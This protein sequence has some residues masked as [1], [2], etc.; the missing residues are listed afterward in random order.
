MMSAVP[1]QIRECEKNN[2]FANFGCE[3]YVNPL[4]RKFDSDDE[5]NEYRKSLSE[6]DQ[7]N[8]GLGSHLLA[9]ALSEKGYRNLVRLTS[10]GW[11][12]GVYRGK[13]RLNHEQLIKYKEDIL[14]TSC[15]YNSEVGRAFD[16]Q[17]PEVAEEILCRYMDMFGDNYIFEIMMLD[18][19]KQ[20]EYNKFIISMHEKYDRPLILSQDC[21]YCHKE[22][23]HNQRLMLMVQTGRT[24]QDI[25]AAK[26]TGDTKDFFELQDQNLWLKSED[27]LN[28]MW[29]SKY[30]KVID[31][32]VFKA[33]KRKTVEIARMASGVKLDR[34]MKLPLFPDADEELKEKVM[35]GFKWRRLPTRSIYLD[36]IK[37][38]YKL[39]CKKEFSSYFLIQKMMVDEAR[40]ICPK[41]IG[42]GDGS[43]AVGPGRGC[44]SFDVPIITKNNGYKFIKD[45]SKGEE[46]LTKSGEFKK[47]LNKQIYDCNESLLKLKSYYGDF[48]GVSLTFDHK[49]YAEKARRPK[50]WET[51][52]E[53][54]KKSRRSF[55]EPEGKLEWLRADELKIGDWL[56]V[57]KPDHKGKIFEFKLEKYCKG[58][59]R[60]GYKTY[61]KDN[62]VFVEHNNSGKSSVQNIVKLDEDFAVILGI[63]AGDGWLRKDNSNKIGFCFNSITDKKNKQ[64][65]KNFFKMK[66]CN[67]REDNRKDKKEV[68]VIV[69]KNYY[70]AQ[71]FRE[72]FS[73]YKYTSRTKHVPEC[74]LNSK[75]N[76][77][78]K[79]LLG[80]MKSDG[81]EDKHKAKITTSSLVMADQVR[82][83]ALCLGVP[84]SLILDARKGDIREEFKNTDISYYI[85]LPLNEDFGTRNAQKN[86]FYKKI[87]GGLLLKLRSIEEIE[88]NGK[89]YD[90]EVEDEHNYVTSSFL[91][92]NSAVG[93][94]VCYC[95]GI[96]DVDPIKEDLIFERFLSEARGGKSMKLRFSSK[97]IKAMLD[98]EY[99][100][101][102]GIEEK[103]NNLPSESLPASKAYEK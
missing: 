54:T 100:E 26:L 85:N 4:Q 63:F 9:I 48:R 10:W 82:Y 20:P 96:T 92:H 13:P 1:T 50:N 45:V 65:V 51:W 88:G 56:F 77:I 94:L 35:Q 97:P 57:P 36:R 49:I 84:S 3:L 14:F 33:A 17:G 25:E 44:L 72:I 28:L 62:E 39:I 93:S 29:E 47:V 81:H 40:R 23:S 83:L 79:F 55:L 69:I 34:S 15:C 64:F 95:L 12:H 102:R 76:I 73:E 38:E 27:E 19:D 24:L 31:Y 91:V 11:L 46:V 41:I 8:F 68:D 21:H 99:I 30:S 87:E 58:T 5:R 101:S 103:L 60:S 74:I 42:W 22:H 32:E 53:S 70:Y 52:S 89:V 61:K 90:I 86:Y 18:F 98:Q 80:L 2:I 43:E 37:R 71:L 16:K 67:F 6:E 7:R 75:E 59:L 78:K 66:G